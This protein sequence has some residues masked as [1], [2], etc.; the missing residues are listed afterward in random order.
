[1]YSRSKREFNRIIIVET[2]TGS[3]CMAPLHHSSINL[4]EVT[5]WNAP[6][7]TKH[8][9]QCYFLTFIQKKKYQKQNADVKIFK[10]LIHLLTDSSTSF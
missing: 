6:I 4:D 9:Q 10:L 7:N 2:V 1:M 8:D 5:I 3:F